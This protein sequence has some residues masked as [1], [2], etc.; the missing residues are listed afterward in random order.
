MNTLLDHPDDYARCA[1]DFD[2][3]TRVVEE[4]LRFSSPATITRRVGQDVVYRDVLLPKGTLL[5]FPVNVSGRDPGSFEEAD[6]FQP[7]R[8]RGNRHLAFG[9]GMHICLGQFIARAQIEE[10]L[11]L[12]AQ[13]IRN[14]RLAGPVGHRPFFGVWGLRGLPIEF[15]PAPGTG[16]A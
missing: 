14:P 2:F 8:E 6:E 11:H 9:R 4:A 3:C 10:G 15:D 16:T 7:E 13:R 5:F 12:I 1:G